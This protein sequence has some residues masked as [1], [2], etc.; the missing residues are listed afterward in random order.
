MELPKFTSDLEPDAFVDKIKV[1]KIFAYKKTTDLDYVD[2]T[3][4]FSKVYFG[5]VV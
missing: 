2:V 4:P 3:F 1:E 5:F